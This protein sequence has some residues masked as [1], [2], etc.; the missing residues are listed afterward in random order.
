MKAKTALEKPDKSFSTK[1]LM[2]RRQTESFSSSSEDDDDNN[3]RYRRAVVS[4]AVHVE[5]GSETMTAKTKKNNK[6]ILGRVKDAI[7]QADSLMESHYYQA[8]L[9]RFGS[10][11]KQLRKLNQDEIKVERMKQGGG[12]KR[13]ATDSVNVL[14]VACHI[15]A[16]HCCSH[17]EKWKETYEHAKEAVDGM[18]GLD[19]D[20]DEEDDADWGK[21]QVNNDRSASSFAEWRVKGAMLMAR[22]LARQRQTKLAIAM[23]GKAR[24]MIRQHHLEDRVL[25][26]TPTVASSPT[27]A[28]SATTATRT[29]HEEPEMTG[30]NT[31]LLL[32][33][34]K[35]NLASASSSPSAL[36][37]RLEQIRAK[38]AQSRLR[39]Q[40]LSQMGITVEYANPTAPPL[41]CR[42]S[43]SAADG[44]DEENID[45]A[46][47]DDDDLGSGEG[48]ENFDC[49]SELTLPTALSESTVT[50]STSVS[51]TTQKLTSDPTKKHTTD[52]IVETSIMMDPV[53]TSFVSV[54]DWIVADDYND[55]AILDTSMLLLEKE[56]K[57]E[58][59]CCILLTA[60]K[61]NTDMSKFLDSMP[62]SPAAV[63]DDEG[64]VCHPLL[65][66]TSPF[67]KVLVAA[68]QEDEENNDRKEEW[69]DRNPV[70]VRACQDSQQDQAKQAKAFEKAAV[71]ARNTSSSKKV[72]MAP[73]KMVTISKR[74]EKD[75][76]QQQ[77]GQQSGL[78]RSPSSPT[79]APPN[80][81]S[82]SSCRVTY[83]PQ[84]AGLTDQQRSR[85][86]AFVSVK[87]SPRKNCDGKQGLRNRTEKRTSS[88]RRS[89]SHDQELST[90]VNTKKV[91]E[92]A[93]TQRQPQQNQRKVRAAEARPIAYGGPSS[94]HAKEKRNN[95]FVYQ[96]C[97][98]GDGE[99]ES[100]SVS[101]SPSSLPTFRAENT[102]AWARSERAVVLQDRELDSK[103][104][105]YMAAGA[106]AVGVLLFSSRRH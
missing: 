47:D 67:P 74:R 22:A 35:A 61:S 75:C 77:N 76:Y 99:H 90:P 39:S 21:I 5:Q 96:H 59:D 6:L 16:A 80:S 94:Q 103:C 97:D 86:K 18:G 106:V 78:I 36:Q 98:V 44:M 33:P 69:S 43:K 89:S 27:P 9:D 31:D 4:P 32:E 1:K 13:N 84:T 7:E 104:A 56:D 14:W 24:A 38:T 79:S 55:N 64:G 23:L 73:S 88:S 19:A 93:A 42:K 20:N 26:Y 51:P 48:L 87:A 83:C 8:A 28:T 101:S 29:T 41:S 81:L 62:S 12:R 11:L 50:A 91:P 34:P 30:K 102:S 65:D 10:A 68:K 15:K 92:S 72:E 85:I 63:Y 82:P 57:K 100:G 46:D 71:L 52:L 54:E 3:I 37:L 66:E 17:L 25:L 58:I 60:G 2:N 40:S 105:L 53:M 95:S 70:T 49:A 45:D